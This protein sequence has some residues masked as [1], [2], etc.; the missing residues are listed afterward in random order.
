MPPKCYNIYH[1]RERRRNRMTIDEV[2]K[3]IARD[4]TRTLELKKDY[5]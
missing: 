5:R 1:V 3:L 2:K 4:E